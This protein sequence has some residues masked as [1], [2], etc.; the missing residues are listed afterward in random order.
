MTRS[1]VVLCKPVRTAIGTYGGTLKASPAPELGAAVAAASL[2]CD[3]GIR[4]E[5][6]ATEPVQRDRLPDTDEQAVR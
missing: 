3:R 1:N 6:S 4:V 2:P 5:H